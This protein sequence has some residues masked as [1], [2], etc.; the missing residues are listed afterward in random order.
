VTESVVMI[1]KIFPV[2]FVLWYS[3]IWIFKCEGAQ[4]Y[5]VSME[6]TTCRLTHAYAVVCIDFRGLSFDCNR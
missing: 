2:L 6:F 1:A 4:I 3:K 5:Q